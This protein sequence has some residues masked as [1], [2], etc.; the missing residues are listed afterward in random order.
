MGM[1]LSFGPQLPCPGLIYI[2]TSEV[3]CADAPMAIIP[4]AKH[5]IIFFMALFFM[6]ITNVVIGKYADLTVSLQIKSAKCCGKCFT[7]RKSCTTKAFQCTKSN[8]L[9]RTALIKQR[10]KGR[11][12]ENAVA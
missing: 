5:S 10:T 11:K 6:C 8:S 2:L 12:F 4:A 9:R 3:L 1:G 7:N